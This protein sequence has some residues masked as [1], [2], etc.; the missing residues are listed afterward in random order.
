MAW[1]DNAKGQCGVPVAAA[2]Q[3]PA[4]TRVHAFDGARLLH[5][6]AGARHSA[7]VQE[8]GALVTF[9]YGR[10]EA[11]SR[12]RRWQSLGHCRGACG[13]SR[14]SGPSGAHSLRS[15]LA[16][17][18]PP[19]PRYGRLGLGHEPDAQAPSAV[20][21]ALR[22]E[23]VAAAACG[24][25]HTL[26]LTAGGR[27]FAFGYNGRG[28]LGAGDAANRLAP[29]LVPGLGPC[30]A[31]AAGAWS[32]AVGAGGEVYAWGDLAP[33]GCG[34]GS[35]EADEG[36]SGGGGGAGEARG[37]GWRRAPLAWLQGMA[38][39]GAAAGVAAGALLSEDGGL[40]LLG[41]PE[42]VPPSLRARAEAEAA[43]EGAEAGAQGE[44]SAADGAQA[45][46]WTQQPAEH[47]GAEGSAEDVAP[48]P[49]WAEASSGSVGAL[50]L[51]LA[52]LQAAAGA[53]ADCNG[54]AFDPELEPPEQV[55]CGE[56]HT[57]LLC[58]PSEYTPSLGEV[59]EAALAVLAAYVSA[60]AGG[61]A[62]GAWG[63]AAPGDRG[64]SAWG[65]DEGRSVW[66]GG[67]AGGGGSAAGG[68]AWGSSSVAGSDGACLAARRRH[69][70]PSTIVSVG[71]PQP[72]R[73]GGDGSRAV[74][75][76]EP[77]EGAS[78]SGTGCGARD[79]ADACRHSKVQWTDRAAAGPAPAAAPPSDLGRR[80]SSVGPLGLP[81]AEDSGAAAGP[82]PRASLAARRGASGALSAE[83]S[84][85]AGLGL[86][87]A[88]PAAAAS[89]E[90]LP[91]RLPPPEAPQEIGLAG[92]LLLCREVGLVDDLTEYQD[93]RGA[94]DSML[95]R[96]LARAGPAAPPVPSPP[97]AAAAAARAG[98]AAAAAADSDSGGGAGDEG[99]GGAGGLSEAMVLVPIARLRAPLPGAAAAAA[100]AL[101]GGGGGSGYTTEASAHPSA[102][103]S[104]G[105]SPLPPSPSLLP[106]TAASCGSWAP[107]AGVAAN[108]L[109]PAGLTSSE[110]LELLLHI[111]RDRHPGLRR[112]A[113]ALLRLLARRHLLRLRGRRPDRGPPW[114][115]RQVLVPGLLATLEGGASAAELLH[116]AYIHLAGRDPAPSD[117]EL[118]L[119]DMRLGL[120]RAALA[121]EAADAARDAGG[122]A[123]AAVASDAAATGDGGCI[124]PAPPPMGVTLAR[125]ADFLRRAGLVPRVLALYVAQ[126][127]RQAGEAGRGGGDGGADIMPSLRLP[128]RG[129]GVGA[130]SRRAGGR[131][132]A[133]RL[134]G[135]PAGALL[136][137]SQGLSIQ[138]LLTRPPPPTP[139]NN[140]RVRSEALPLRRQALGAVSEEGAP[141]PWGHPGLAG[142]DCRP[143]QRAPSPLG[144]CS[145]VSRTASAATHS[146]ASSDVGGG[147]LLSAQAVALSRTPSARPPEPRL[148]RGDSAASR[149]AGSLPGGALLRSTSAQRPGGAASF[150]CRDAAAASDGG[151][152]DASLLDEAEL[153]PVR[154]RRA[155]R[156]Q[157]EVPAGSDASRGGAAGAPLQRAARAESGRSSVAMQAPAGRA[158]L[159]VE[160]RAA[161]GGSGRSSPSLTAGST[162]GRGSPSGRRE[163]TY[164]E[165]QAQL[166]AQANA[167]ASAAAAAEQ[168][169]QQRQVTWLAFA[170]AEL[171]GSYVIGPAAIQPAPAG[172]PTGGSG[173]YG[174]PIDL[175]SARVCY[176]QFLE[177]L[178]VCAAMRCSGVLDMGLKALA[179][180][181]P[182]G[183]LQVGAV[184]GEGGRGAGI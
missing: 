136:P 163:P 108:R 127:Q 121:A 47:E 97:A 168:R 6:A 159:R 176:P 2:A 40:V 71:L 141:A 183:E 82:L 3:L 58:G 137:C 88:A 99:G 120:R 145:G 89:A 140:H 51:T 60:A 84:I 68:G 182:K 122:G 17:S 135:K 117:L 175:L 98:C 146:N 31:V 112:D 165:Q 132:W 155:S 13:C 49:P 15:H 67:S 35:A 130:G 131:R 169:E 152:V 50:A 158:S 42:L 157:S 92:V 105:G 70:V 109:A 56:A 154:P 52:A 29:S 36:G 32:A 115:L 16:P 62:A 54:D 138:H 44:P 38:F 164:H 113:D 78:G 180:L 85:A 102:C 142:P 7:V 148:L 19:L 95:H 104:R 144:G 76:V 41:C 125:L 43:S 18:F 23:P 119:S 21:G 139:L 4:P 5:V 8:G 181:E 74:S 11:L 87:S 91:A 72:R 66:G 22:S 114:L 96:K 173:G 45:A 149:T 101:R 171:L 37:P 178:L 75:F 48:L 33:A 46:L 57:V 55:A 10:C 94:F 26:A 179:P 80:P 1:G 166:R 161:A 151:L 28:A 64:G 153:V 77:G 177:V 174:A 116:A 93:V 103:S 162:A 20:G 134:G 12:Q 111:M 106:E 150:V 90:G 24:A 65:G 9:G 39:R 107:Q 118:S 59:R 25:A 81:A 34:G 184:R 126:L 63:L 61:G 172:H 124:G 14:P 133:Q 30:R 69:Y 143:P 147:L 53:G 123:A 170:L 83:P 129:G 128:L 160:L 73:G 110:L 156:A 79:A 27:V 167:A 86:S 100:A